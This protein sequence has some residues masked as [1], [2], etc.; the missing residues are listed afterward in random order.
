MFIFFSQRLTKVTIYSN[1]NTFLPAWCNSSGW[2]LNTLWPKVK[3]QWWAISPLATMLSTLFNNWTIFYGDFSGFCH[4]VFK[5]V[6]CRFAVCR[7][8][9]MK[10]LNVQI[11]YKTSRIF[12]K[13]YIFSHYS[14]WLLQ[15]TLFFK[16]YI[17]CETSLQ[18]R[19]ITLDV[20]FLET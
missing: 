14:L 4:Y 19:L 9:C 8:I 16:F 11:K 6:C 17:D 13:V 2:L 15:Y 5:V 20:C 10:G 3:L 12:I 1:N 18:L 7:I